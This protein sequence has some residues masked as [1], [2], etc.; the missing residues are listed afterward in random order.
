MIFKISMKAV[1]LKVGRVKVGV[2]DKT[3]YFN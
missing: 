1:N 3:K 2:G